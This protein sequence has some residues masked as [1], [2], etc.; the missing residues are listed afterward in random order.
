[1]P[2]ITES[3]NSTLVAVY[4]SGS[5]PT[6]SPVTRQ[7]SLNY[8]RSDASEEALYDVARAL[9]SLSLHPLLEVLQRKNFRLIEE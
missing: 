1:M 5:T 6:G 8:V 3:L 4:Q 9:F 7:K 2:I